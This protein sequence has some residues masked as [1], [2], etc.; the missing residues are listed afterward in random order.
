MKK[1]GFAAGHK[2]RR[3][4]DAGGDRAVEDGGR[5]AMDEAGRRRA[6]GC[7]EC[8]ICGKAFTMSGNLVR[9]MLTHTGE[10]P[11]VCETCGKAFAQSG[12]LLTR[13]MRVHTGDK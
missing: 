5:R 10:K 9:H 7:L 1:G 12:S 2:R 3:S 8:E 4:A 13:H 6:T 11:H